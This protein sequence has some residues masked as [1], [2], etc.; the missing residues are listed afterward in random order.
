MSLR[1]TDCADAFADE[2]PQKTILSTFGMEASAKSPDTSWIEKDWDGPN[3]ADVKMRKWVT[4]EINLLH[5][6]K[7]NPCKVSQVSRLIFVLRDVSQFTRHR[8]EH[9][10][11]VYSASLQVCI[12]GIEGRLSKYVSAKSVS[13]A[14]INRTSILVPLQD[15]ISSQKTRD[16]SGEV[17]SVAWTVMYAL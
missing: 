9:L 11:S 3:C 4:K 17:F 14:T 1:R 5:I 13:F 15:F 7:R 2:A 6:R 12:F 16:S 8:Q 10:S